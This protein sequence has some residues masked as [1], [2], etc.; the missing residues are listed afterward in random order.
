MPFFAECISLKFTDQEVREIRQNATSLRG[1]LEKRGIT[2]KPED[3]LIISKGV[4]S[5]SL[6]TIHFSPISTD[7]RPECYLIEVTE[8]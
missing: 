8:Y 5:F 6:R 1:F 3:A 7:E 2:F 4:L